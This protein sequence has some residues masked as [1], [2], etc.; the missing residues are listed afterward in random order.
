MKFKHIIKPKIKNIYIKVD[1]NGEVTL[2]SSAYRKKE[3]LALMEKKREWIKRAIDKS[4][5]RQKKDNIYKDNGRIY[6]FGRSY[7]FVYQKSSQEDISFDGDNI[8]Y[9]YK[10]LKDP[11]NWVE[12]FYK[13]EISKFISLRIS[14]FSRKLSLYPKDIKYRKM[15]R[16]LGSC[17]GDDVLTFN[18]LLAK[19][20]YEQI[21]YVIVHELSHI[22]HKN[23]SKDF[24]NEVSKI[25]PDYKEIRKSITL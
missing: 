25:F 20:P 13:T 5:A 19:L 18:T 8:Y 6:L 9:R 3:A 17:S 23:H 15:K 4:L 14:Y 21:D 16:R 12:K 22:K 10:I 7:P 2:T 1:K 24:W 11:K